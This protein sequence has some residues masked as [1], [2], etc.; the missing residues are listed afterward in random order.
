MS[1]SNTDQQSGI[2]WQRFAWQ[3]IQLEFPPDW[4]PGVLEGTADDGY[5]RIDDAANPRLEVRWQRCR[6]KQPISSVVDSYLDELARRHSGRRSRKRKEL[7]FPVKRDTRLVKVPDAECEVF[8]VGPPSS[9][10]EQAGTL[11]INLAVYCPAS[12]RVSIVRMLGPPSDGAPSRAPAAGAAPT[13]KRRG[14]SKASGPAASMRPAA[15]R[16]LRSFRDFGSVE[17]LTWSVYGLRI[18]LP[19]R[20]RLDTH[21]FQAGRIEMGFFGKAARR[22]F[23]GSEAVAVRIGLAGIALRRQSL[24]DLLRKDRIGKPWA[25]ETGFTETKVK[26]HDGVDIAVVPRQRFRRFFSRRLRVARAWHCEPS[27]AIYVA[28]WS[29]PEAR[30]SDFADFVQSFVCHE[31]AGSGIE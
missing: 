6:R 23:G 3:G 22:R 16:V 12:R 9:G 31:N 15:K 26:G 28:C 5:C 13:G 10:G 2:K 7:P 8:E 21:V 11:S 4:N 17:R 24:S 25:E 14:P 20:Y 1:S 19:A 30:R 29:G 18:G 27:N